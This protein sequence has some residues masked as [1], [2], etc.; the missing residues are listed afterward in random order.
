MSYLDFDFPHTHMYDSDLRELLRMYKK[1]VEDYAEL[2]AWKN[3]HTVD[4]KDLLRRVILLENTISTFESEITHQFEKLSRELSDELY[5]QL[6]EALSVINANLGSISSR[7]DNLKTEVIRNRIEAHSETIAY[8]AMGKQYTDDK[9]QALIDSLP[10]IITID[11]FN[12]VK[13]RITNIQI[14][15]NDLYDLGRANGLTA[16]EYDT[17]GITASEYDALELTAIEYDQYGK[18]YLEQGGYIKNQFHYMASPFTGLI[19]P[20]EVV[21]TELASVHK[22]YALTAEEYDE[23]ELSASEYDALLLGAYDYDWHGKQHI[24]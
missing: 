14:A 16:I 9:I 10:K 22:L 12:P 5:S 4:Y 24:A 23:K 6:Q 8:Y 1:L 2:I 20:L 11:V 13:G 7:L 15:I 19:V 21:I 18:Y 3:Q 17:I